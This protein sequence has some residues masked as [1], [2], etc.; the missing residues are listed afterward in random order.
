MTAIKVNRV[1]TPELARELVKQGVRI[2]GVPMVIDPRFVEPW[3]VD[4]AT[5]RAIVDAAG[6]AVVVAHIDASVDPDTIRSELDEAGIREVELAAQPT[7]P[8]ALLQALRDDNLRIG[9]CR[10]VAALDDD[11]DW[12]LGPVADHDPASIERVELELSPAQ[13]DGWAALRDADPDDELGLGDIDVLAGGRTLFV[14]FGAG[15][16]NAADLAAHL[17]NVAGVSFH[18]GTVNRAHATAHAVDAR[19]LTSAVARL[20]R[21]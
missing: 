4:A 11:P 13:A 21:R 14:S 10:L 20:R 7:P 1:T 12:I 19:T 5:A 18:L 9:F 16:A 17:P 3:R 15:S 2:I 8:A 6:A